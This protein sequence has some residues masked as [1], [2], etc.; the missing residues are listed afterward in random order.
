M[1]VYQKKLMDNFCFIIQND[2]HKYCARHNIQK[3]NETFLTFLFDLH[4]LNEAK[5]RKYTILEAY[6][7]LNTS[8]NFQ[9]TK[10]VGLLAER[11]NITSRSVWLSLIHISEPTRPY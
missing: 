10:A 2:F 9:K 5:I 1:P 11:F 6:E 3:N 7:E 8:P 4:L